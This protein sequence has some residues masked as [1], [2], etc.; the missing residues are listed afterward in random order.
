VQSINEKQAE[1]GIKIR[2]SQISHELRYIMATVINGHKIIIKCHNKSS[3]CVKNPCA[4][5][6]L[7]AEKKISVT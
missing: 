4:A 1:D 6:V 5:S 2:D 7:Q 3:H